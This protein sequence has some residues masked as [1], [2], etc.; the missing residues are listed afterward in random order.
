[1]IGVASRKAKRAASS[2]ERPDQQAAA[3]RRA[4]AREAGDEG[5]RLGGAHGH[6]LRASR[7]ARRCGVAVVLALGHARRA[8]PQPLGAEQHDPVQ[9][10]EERR[11]AGRREHRLQLVL[12]QQAQDARPG[13]WRRR[14]ASPAGRRGSAARSRARRAN[15]TCRVRMRTQS[16]PEEPEQDDG[17]RQVRRH[18]EGDEVLVVLVDVPAEHARRDHA[19]AQAR[20]REQLGEALQQPEDRRPGRRRSV[21]QT[22]RINSGTGAAPVAAARR[23]RSGWRG[24]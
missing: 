14:S 9:D 8:P 7:C 1:M 20:D 18:Q 23:R 15:A 13:S 10:Q 2:F 12:Q 22:E 6:R 21:R 11:R 16:R 4:R 24:R 17:R 19:L 3:H 5:D